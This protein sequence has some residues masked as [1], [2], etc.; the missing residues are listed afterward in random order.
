MN[1]PL[2]SVVVN[3]LNG[4]LT[5]ETA[6]NSALAQTGVNLEVVVWDNGSSDQTG[7]LVLGMQDERI[8]YF[9][10]EQTVPLYEARIGAISQCGGDFISFLDADDWWL[11]NKLES[12]LELFRGGVEAVYS[13]YFIANEVS[14]SVKPYSRRLLPSGQ[15][16]SSLLERYRV[17]LLTLI[18]RREVFE[19]HS[20]DASLEIIGDFDFVMKLASETEFGC[21]QEPLAWSRFTGNNESERKKARHLQELA[22][23]CENGEVSGLLRGRDLRNMRRMVRAK[24]VEVAIEGGHYVRGLVEL[25]RVQPIGRQFK[26]AQRIMTSRRSRRRLSE[27]LDRP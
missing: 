4:A 11:E 8:R 16:F 20:F 26:V 12:Q 21:V 2:V 3:V 25:L 1:T 10:T 24:Q 5:I 15:V 19:R 9:R 18:V 17:G 27:R 23:W 13:N 6:L 14:G 7:D 22:Q